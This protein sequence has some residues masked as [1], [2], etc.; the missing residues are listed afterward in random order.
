MRPTDE[1]STLEIE[2]VQLV[3]SLLSIHYI[4]IDNKSSAFGVSCNTLANLAASNVSQLARKLRHPRPDHR[5]PTH[6]TGPNLPK[7]SNSSSGVTL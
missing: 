7:R 5:A 4:F 1:I 6:R 2:T 3:T